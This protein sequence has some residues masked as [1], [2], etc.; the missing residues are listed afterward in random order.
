MIVLDTLKVGLVEA[1][2]RRFD[3]ERLGGNV[4]G[5]TDFWVTVTINGGQL[6]AADGADLL[7]C[8]FDTG[9]ILWSGEVA[10][11]AAAVAAVVAIAG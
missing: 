9:E 10:D 3:V 2:G 6:D 5:L 4:Y 7:V 11:E 8:Q 1:T